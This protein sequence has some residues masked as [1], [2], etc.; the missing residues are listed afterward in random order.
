MG[1]TLLIASP[2]GHDPHFE[3]TLVLVWH[4]DENGAIGVVVNRALQHGLAEV[5]EL[6][7]E[8]RAGAETATVGWGGPVEGASGTVL[9]R[10]HVDDDEGWNLDEGI[11]ITRSQQQLKRLLAAREPFAL[12]LGYAGWGPGQLDREIAEG[13]WLWTEADPALIFDVPA[14]DRYDRALA[15]LGVAADQVWMAP[16]EE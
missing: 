3:R 8:E 1:P 10:A 16:V 6:E 9:T 5:V 2:Q 12:L 7:D 15:T 4:H 11:G 13:G 14:P